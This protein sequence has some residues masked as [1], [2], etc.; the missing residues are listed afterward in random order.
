MV[1]EI[2]VY[3]DL[4]AL[5]RAAA[6]L[7]FDL[8][9]QA[10][11]ERGRFLAALNGGS[12]PKRLF[13][14]LAG[15]KSGKI[16]W[17]AVHIFWGDERCVPPDDAESNYGQARDQF[18]GQVAIPDGNVHRIPGELGPQAASKEYDLVLKKFASPPLDWPSFD[19]VF[20]GIGEDGHT[21]SL[22]PGSSLDVP[23]PTM[24]V[25]ALY[26]D[27]PAE[28]VTL[29]PLVFNS[30]RM[31]LFMAVGENKAL[32]LSRVLNDGYQPELYPAQRIEPKNGKL[33][34]LV[35]EAAAAKLPKE[36]LR[37]G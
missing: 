10:T 32:T 15:V 37:A 34:W 26:Q 22:F 5:S 27:R 20:L 16:T 3:N 12:T 2:R 1:P 33:I 6:Q 17:K 25:S 21:A 19:L 36:L 31:I 35:D 13:Q 14:L 28:R 18:L 8:A 4:E 24:A 9:E 7:F 30:S 29:T 11:R 23:G